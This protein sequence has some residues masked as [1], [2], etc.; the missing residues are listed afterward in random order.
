[1]MNL[2]LLFKCILDVFGLIL[3]VIL[4]IFLVKSE[5]YKSLQMVASE[6]LLKSLRT[7][8]EGHNSLG[9]VTLEGSPKFSN[10]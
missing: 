2:L 3:N 10:F 1:M 7:M 9:R 5:S 8:P 4:E 6:G